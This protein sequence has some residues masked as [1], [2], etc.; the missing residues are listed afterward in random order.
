MNYRTLG[1][2]G[3]KVSEIAFG[4][5]WYVERPYSDVEEIVRHCEENGI[6]SKTYYRW[7]RRCLGEA[8]IRLGYADKNPGLIRVNPDQLPE[9]YTRP[10]EAV[11]PGMEC[12]IRC[13]QILI[14]I[15][16][17]MPVSRIADLVGALNNHA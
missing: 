11:S 12:V 2:T 9:G 13:G 6:N 4:A 1:N 17:E 8:A 14:E 10:D 5:E 7:E 3:L 16:A 15:N